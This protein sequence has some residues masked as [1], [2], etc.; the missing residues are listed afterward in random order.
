M[1]WRHFLLA[2]AVGAG[3]WSA[4]FGIAAYTF[5]RQFA[6]LA[7][8][9]SLFSGPSGWCIFGVA[10]AIVVFLFVNFVGRHEAQLAAK[11]ERAL[12]GPLRLP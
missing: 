1:P 12:P 11:A 5:G 10:A 3:L 4:F 9:W 6:R 8:S 7:A 2:S